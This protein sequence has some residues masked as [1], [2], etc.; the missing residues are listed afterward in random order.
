MAWISDAELAAAVSNAGGLGVIAC[1]NA[2]GSYVKE[3]IDK[4]RTMTDKPYGLNVMLL[5]PYVEEVAK[6]CTDEK[7]PVV[8]TG[9]GDPSK[10]IKGWQ[11]NGTKVIP[12]VASVALAKRME[13]LGVDALIAE[14]GEAG[15]HVGELNTMTLVPAVTDAVDLPVIAAGGIFDGRGVLAA[16][17]LGAVG[18]QVG[19]RFLLAEECT[20]HENYKKK[21]VK[22]KDID[23][24]V[25]GR[26]T[27]HPVRV[28]RNPLSKELKKMDQAGK[29][30]EEI[31]S[32]SA[33]SLY[34][35]AI[36]GDIKTG[37]FMAGQ[38]ACMVSEI[39]PAA[40]IIESLL[41]LSE[42]YLQMTKQV[43]AL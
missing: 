24:F 43:E 30:A 38:C 9:A 5:S 23:S 29:S 41:D 37:S 42:S 32:F 28:L 18:V 17:A 2:P 4:I 10:Y 34:R 13:R 26:N 12:V 22:A 27:G 1:G 7:V 25:T 33:G 11:A 6:I 15:G 36:E 19:T 8:I 21:V 39:E 20:V 40:K 31:E 35:A 16:F 14:G 3:Q